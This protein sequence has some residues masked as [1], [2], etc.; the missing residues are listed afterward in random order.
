MRRLCLLFIIVGLQL[1][2]NL[3]QNVS[4]TPTQAVVTLET[5]KPATATIAVPTST[6]MPSFGQTVAGVFLHDN[7]TLNIYQKAGDSSSL[8]S[9]LDPHISGLRL[10]GREEIV[11]EEK[12]LEVTLDQGANGWVDSGFVTPYIPPNDFCS[13]TMVVDFLD[14][15]FAKLESKDGEGFSRLISPYQGLRIRYHW[16]YQEVH[17]FNKDEL[18]QIFLSNTTYEWGED[19][20]IGENIVGPFQEV[21]YP[22]L[23]QAGTK[24]M[25]YCNTLEQGL[26]ADWVEGFIQWP[27]EYT[28]LN[29]MTIFVSAPEGEDL[30]W[31]SY[32]LGIEQYDQQYY[33]AVIV[34]YKWDY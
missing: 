19:K 33:L 28:N 16:S 12:W 18:E 34:Q 10:T 20:I 9:S 8:L 24:G 23:I 31:R 29:Y 5:A 2:C 21:I 7:E 26:A 6:P 3:T 11:G 14:D 32:A 25:R 13:Q 27:F 1:S 15:L 17:I 4:K 22:G 30:N